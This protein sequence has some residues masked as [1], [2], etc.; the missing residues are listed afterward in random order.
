MKSMPTVIGNVTLSV[1]SHFHSDG[2][3]NR[4]LR[5]AGNA[6]RDNAVT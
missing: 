6:F 2:M 3:D 4:F 5:N 1:G